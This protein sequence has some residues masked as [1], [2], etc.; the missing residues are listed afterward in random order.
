MMTDISSE[1]ENRRYGFG[2]RGFWIAMAIVLAIPVVFAIAIVADPGS[3]PSLRKIEQHASVK[4]PE[5]AKLLNSHG[6]TFLEI[7]ILAKVE[8][9]WDVV[10]EFI[11]SL[12]E[13]RST[14]D[15]V[16]VGHLLHY[17]FDWWNPGSAK[18]FRAVK[19]SGDDGE[20]RHRIWR[21]LISLDDPRKAVIYL[22][23]ARF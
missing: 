4:F 18:C 23:Y 8:M 21:I 14:M 2:S 12:P 10:D 6:R 7:H 1:P 9:D 5:S 16:D 11:S 13:T 17:D 3:H 20:R 15:D 22:E 19:A